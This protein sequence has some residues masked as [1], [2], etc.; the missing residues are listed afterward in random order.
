MRSSEPET[1]LES[2]ME[3]A[4]LVRDR[5][6]ALFADEM[7]RGL[8]NVHLE[9]AI[10]VYAKVLLS[11]QKLRFDLGLDEKKRPLSCEKSRPLSWKQRAEQIERDGKATYEAY[12]A[13]EE[14]FANLYATRNVETERSEAQKSATEINVT[15]TH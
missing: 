13:A 10:N 14:V 4:D 3:L 8:L 6:L 15:K 5:V 2:L 11:I 7:K 1:V 9:R 12:A